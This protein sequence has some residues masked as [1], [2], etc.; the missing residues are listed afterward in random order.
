MDALTGDG[1]QGAR[2]RALRE[3]L[4]RDRLVSTFSTAD[5][6]A[7]KVS[8]AVVRQL[9]ARQHTYQLV[10]GLPPVPRQRAWTIPPPVRSFTGR[11]GLLAELRMR[12]MGKGAATLVP[13]AAL[14]GMG[15]VGKTQLA[16]AYA[17]RHRGDYQLGWWVP[18]ETE[19]GM[20]AALADLAVA[21]GLSA[22]LP[23]AELARGARDALGGRSGWLLIFDNAPDPAAVA[24]YLPGAG[25]GHVLVT[26]R[27]SAW[28]G[29]ADPVPVDLLPQEDAVGLLLSRSGDA[30]LHSAARLAEALG[31]LP[32]A[33]EQ[34]AAYATSQ[35]LPLARYLK[36]FTGRRA[37]LLALG[38]P[39]A[40]QGT[41]DATFTLAID[42]LRA[43]K[44]AAGW[45]LEICALLDPDRLP[46]EQLLEDVERLP[47]PVRVVAANPLDRIELIG[48]LCRAGLLFNQTN[49]DAG[50]DVKGGAQAQIVGLHRLTQAV[51]VAHLG[52]TARTQRLAEATTLLDG[53]FPDNAWDLPATWPACSRLIAHVLALSD[54]ANTAKHTT[55]EL[56]WLLTAAA[57]YLFARGLLLAIAR[58]L[59]Q[60]A[61]AMFERLH[62]PGTDHPDIARSLFYVAGDLRALGKRAE[63]RELNERALAMLER[64]YG[65]DADEPDLARSLHFLAVDVHEA[66][67]PERAREL[68]ERALAIRERLYRRDISSPT[69]PQT[70]TRDR[71]GTDSRRDLA[72]SLT[73]LANN[74]RV[75]GE[76]KRARE[77]DERALAI[78]EQ[79]YGA[80]ADHPHIAWSMANLAADLLALGKPDRA[81]ELDEHA[82]AMRKRL[83]KDADHPHIA[84]S[85]TRVAA[86][87]RALGE[88]EQALES[89][90]QALEMYQRLYGDDHPAVAASLT[91][92]TVDLRELGEHDR[93]RELDEQ[94]LAMR[95]RL[96]D[97]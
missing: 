81:H 6:L 37:E 39:L 69:A 93:A 51:V 35:R 64:L 66:G 32:L 71:T 85:L 2:I 42:K 21:L 22:E 30:D 70:P 38:K 49:L 16:L 5:E 55:F 33:L 59:H 88:P 68:N 12:L 86:D 31:R 4:G 15:G 90:E 9:S 62:G 82:L 89:D 73:N 65:P 79:V 74:L 96:A 8:V 76:P 44:P 63:S 1:D 24:E 27:D 41:V 43:T 34:A 72:W 58:D 61:S 3:E 83:Y 13:T 47:G 50:P 18:A 17:Q 26:S 25:G 60:Q 57:H 23:A 77:L 36:L 7:Q 92:L 20:L 54:H 53:Q 45:L 97:Q 84:W 94:A 80:G 40:Y 56:A 52:A 46:V 29:I 48:A 87:L 10:A 67:E 28:Q 75:L 14:Y 78:R 91:N 95:R 19:L 11:L